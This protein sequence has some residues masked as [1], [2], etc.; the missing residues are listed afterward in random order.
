MA[1]RTPKY[2]QLFCSRDPLENERYGVSCRGMND[3]RCLCS[4]PLLPTF[5]M[6]TGGVPVWVVCREAPP[7]KYG[8]R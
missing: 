5:V 7:E 4:S 2:V 3:P 6:L 8:E 1:L